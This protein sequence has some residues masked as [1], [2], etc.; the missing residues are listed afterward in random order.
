MRLAVQGRS[1]TWA[2][3]AAP[4]YDRVAQ[5][6]GAGHLE[7]FAVLPT[8]GGFTP[9]A[10]IARWRLHPAESQHATGALDIHPAH[11]SAA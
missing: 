1:E 9:S 10:V 11:E 6:A 3:H 7:S 8:T 5:R 4:Q 2:V